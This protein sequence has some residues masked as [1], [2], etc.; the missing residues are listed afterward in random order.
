[1]TREK[2]IQGVSYM[3]K[4]HIKHIC[5]HCG[6]E[7]L[8]DTAT[9]NKL[10]SG[11]Y[12]HSYCSMECK[13]TATRVGW[14]IKCTNCGKE[15][16][17]KKS[18][19]DRHDN[20]FC[21][22][23]CEFGY[24]HKQTH[25]MRNCE[26]CG[27]VFEVSKKSKQR[28]CCVKCQNEW[29]KTQNGELNFKFSNTYTDCEYCGE[30]YRIKPYKLDNRQH[31]FCSVECRQSWYAKIW[32]QQDW[33]K[34]KSRAKMLELLNSGAI[35]NI[36]S[37]PQAIVDD[38]LSNL[39]I[40]SEKEYNIKYYSID[41]YLTNCNLM[42]EVQGDYWH[43]NPQ[44]F[45]KSLTKTQ[46]DRIRKDKAKNTYIKN[47]YNI[48]VL[49]LWESDIISRINVCEKLILKYINCNGVLDDYNSFNYDINE[50]CALVLKDDLTIPYQNKKL[51][52]YR[53]LFK[54]VS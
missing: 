32:S 47:N 36:N 48:S 12:K 31:N 30:K 33:W 34:E 22:I 8:I 44:I 53:Y 16:Y 11:K 40:S 39:N 15:F 5:D 28:F 46:Y 24:K 35:N 4:K 6:V 2:E 50:C 41:N 52:E 29:Q 23:E 10:L 20:N 49:Y 42:I 26:T 18:H 3:P 17:R 38:L 54:K 45:N 1:M 21:C 7:H 9:Y 43:S 25:E 13:K 14:I 19:L 37:K 51:S 27:F